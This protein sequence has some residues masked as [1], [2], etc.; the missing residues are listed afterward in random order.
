MRLQAAERNAPSV[1]KAP[2]LPFFLF[3]QH[4]VNAV[5]LTVQVK[6]VVTL[7]QADALK[8]TLLAANAACD[9][10]SARAWEHKTF[11]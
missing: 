10:I 5:K 9:K 1:P 6:R 11:S 8:R 7:E 4:S 3:L 2:C